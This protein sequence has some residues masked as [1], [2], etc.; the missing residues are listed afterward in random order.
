[1]PVEL[2]ALKSEILVVHL[3]L[4][5]AALAAIS[6]FKCIFTGPSRDANTGVTGD[7]GIRIQPLT[8]LVNQFYIKVSFKPTSRATH[9]GKYI[10]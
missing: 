10:I 9:G 8:L 2:E 4:L 6:K 3:N 7:T 1:M 5:I